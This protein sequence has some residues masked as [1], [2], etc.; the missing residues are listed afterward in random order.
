MVKTTVMRSL[1]CGA[2][3]IAGTLVS[4]Q[5]A[6]A[7]P[8]RFRFTPPYGDPFPNLYWFGEAVVDD[9]GCGLSGNV[10]NLFGTCAGQFTITSATVKFAHIN[11]PGDTVDIDDPDV[12][13]QSID[14]TG[15]HVIS[16][17]RDGTAPP[18]WKQ[19]VSTPFNTERGG[20]AETIYDP[21]G[22]GPLKGMQAYFSLIFVGGFAQLYWFQ[23]DPGDPLLDPLSF[24][25]VQWPNAAYY[26]G[27]YLAGPGDN[28]VGLPYLGIPNNQC[29]LSSNLDGKG[30]ALFGF[31]DAAAAVPEPGT[32][33][34]LLAAGLGAVGLR[35]RRRNT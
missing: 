34:L 13:L 9:G 25:Y 32:L 5:P 14:F 21:D 18:D 30:A 10:S 1:L 12:V 6:E 20:I 8:V 7:G 27:C 33:A 11:A 15:G 19:V 3:A 26:A 17:S 23:N 35:A 4:L 22:N 24:P 28:T 16:V 29:G 2:L 31:T